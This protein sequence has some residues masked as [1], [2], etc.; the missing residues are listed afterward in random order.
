MTDT[1]E[2]A[3]KMAEA[4]AQLRK[5]MEALMPSREAQARRLDALIERAALARPD[6]TE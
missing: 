5:D 2:L 3:A 4:S 6:P 1:R